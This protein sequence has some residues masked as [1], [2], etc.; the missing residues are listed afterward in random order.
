MRSRKAQRFPL[1]TFASPPAVLPLPTGCPFHVAAAVLAP[2]HTG[3]RRLVSGRA[4][5]ADGAFNR[6]VMEGIERSS[7]VYTGREQV[8][9]A[10]FD[11]IQGSAIDP[12]D[13]LKYSPRQLDHAEVWNSSADR[14]QWIPGPFNTGRAISW[15]E[16]EH[17]STGNRGYAPA[18]YC[19]LS[20]PNCYDIGFCLADSSGLAAGLNREEATL[21]A[22]LEL[23][24]R[25]A[26]SIWWYNR[27]KLPE[28]TIPQ[29]QEELVRLFRSWLRTLR[30]KLHLIDLTNDLEIP[31]VAALA[32]GEDG[33]GF[34]FGSAAGPDLHQAIE[35]ALGEVCQFM[36]SANFA[37]PMSAARQ[38]I[39]PNFVAW[40]AA[41]SLRRNRHLT[42]SGR[43]DHRR[44]H[45]GPEDVLGKLRSKAVD[46]FVVC[47]SRDD[48]PTV[49][50]V[51]APALRPIWPRYAEGRLFEVPVAMGARKR[52]ISE[53]DLNPTA[54]LY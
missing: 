27:L 48:A 54:I 52:P 15:L 20:Y 33:K 23:V 50:R 51:L 24:E 5:T 41:A 45:A 2:D 14:D 32:Y 43:L 31:V 40:A 49:V 47:L 28:V 7:A 26:V 34:W 13:L 29:S 6:T 39:P 16:I 18:A 44:E 10:T 25:D 53:S 19:L 1:L 9:V 3:R 30:R 21:R 42:P 46:L 35:G 37:R 4:R 11:E 12:R 17:V 22:V 36:L 38:A 8:V